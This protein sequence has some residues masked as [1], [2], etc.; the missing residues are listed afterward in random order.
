MGVN[1]AY[2]FNWKSI[3]VVMFKSQNLM[4]WLF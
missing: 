3:S 2:T 1:M 4:D